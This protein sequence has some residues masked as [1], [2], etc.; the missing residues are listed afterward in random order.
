MAVSWTGRRQACTA[1]S[2]GRSAGV[3]AIVRIGGGVSGA[4]VAGGVAQLANSS[5]ATS[6]ISQFDWG[7]RGFTGVVYTRTNTSRLSATR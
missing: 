3:K 2:Q 4:L 6:K 7:M 1:G 5:A